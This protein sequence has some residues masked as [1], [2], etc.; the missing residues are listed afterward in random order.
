MHKYKL[1]INDTEAQAVSTRRAKKWKARA[2]ARK[3][4]GLPTIPYSKQTMKR[5]T[6]K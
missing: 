4:E 5:K 3:N 2:K 1:C 6:K